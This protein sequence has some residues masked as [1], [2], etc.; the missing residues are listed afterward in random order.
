MGVYMKSIYS[1][2]IHDLETFLLDNNEK[3]YRASQ[4]MD[5]LYVKRVDSFSKM[6]NL[7]KDLITKLDAY[8]D[9]NGSKCKCPRVDLYIY[10]FKNNDMIEDFK[11][12]Y[13]MEDTTDD[14]FNEM[15]ENSDIYDKQLTMKDIKMIAEMDKIFKEN[16]NKKGKRLKI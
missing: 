14:E 2:T 3:K 15:I 16:I 11:K 5:W 8:Y 10:L 12:Y 13:I 7:S 4:I 6:T 9:K 1:M